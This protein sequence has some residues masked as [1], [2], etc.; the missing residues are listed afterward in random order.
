MNTN[1]EFHVYFPHIDQNEAYLRLRQALNAIG[2]EMTERFD[3]VGS[4][5]ALLTW[6]HGHGRVTGQVYSQLRQFDCPVIGI[7]QLQPGD[8]SDPVAIFDLQLNF[9]TPAMI[10]AHAVYSQILLH[11]SRKELN[12]IISQ[13]NFHRM[14]LDDVVTLGM[15]LTQILSYRELFQLVVD[16]ANS[17]LPTLSHAFFTIDSNTG[18]CLLSSFQHRSDNKQ[19]QIPSA[20]KL[21]KKAILELQTSQKP[22][23]VRSPCQSPRWV[24]RLLELFNRPHTLVITPVVSKHN[25]LG[26]LVSFH[27]SERYQDLDVDIERLEVLAAFSAVSI[28]NA[29]VYE[30]TETLSRI[31]DLTGVYNFFFIQTR[32]DQL[33]KDRCSFALIFFDLDGFKL[34]N[35]RFGHKTGNRALRETADKITGMMASDSICG[36]FGGDEFVVIMQNTPVEKAKVWTEKVIQ[37]IEKIVIGSTIRLSASAG[38]AEFPD[39]ANDLNSIIHAADTAMYAAKDLGR[40]YVLSFRNL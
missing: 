33:I 6:F 37:S 18:D 40:G 3:S 36:R 17:L 2:I 34:I 10:I 21:E 13:L 12:D 28:G 22:L 19:P 8:K 27:L 24:H 29:F 15:Q 16:H 35:Q 20:F 25:L 39:D 23:I 4:P 11:R 38:I 7:E 30:Q 9:N 14:K 31:D 26:L 5:D 32:L 1:H